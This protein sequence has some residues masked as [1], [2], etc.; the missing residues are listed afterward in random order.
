MKNL[1]SALIGLVIIIGILAWVNPSLFNNKRNDANRVREA[2]S[3]RSSN[4]MVEVHGR[5]TANLPDIDDGDIF[6]QFILELDNKHLVIVSHNVSEAMPVP[7]G[8]GSL[9]RIKGEYDWTP[10]GGKIHWTH[11]DP[12]G[13]REGGWIETQGKRFQ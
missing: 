12:S 6:Q 9:V 13:L 10:E 4:I 2:F 1:K 3:S 8:P 5:V 11:A 7:V